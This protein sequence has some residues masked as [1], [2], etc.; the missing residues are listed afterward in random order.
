MIINI[1]GVAEDVL[2]TPL[3]VIKGNRTI[4]DLKYEEKYIISPNTLIF[5]PTK[6]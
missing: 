3:S 1:P 6:G 5:A 4:A 2:Q